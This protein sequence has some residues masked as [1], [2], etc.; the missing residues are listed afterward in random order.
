LET[1][2]RPTVEIRIRP[3]FGGDLANGFLEVLATLSP[4]E[5]SIA[6]AGEVLRERLR[7]GIQTFVALVG[8]QVVGTASLVLEKKFI[9]RGGHVGH[10]EDVAVRADY[11]GHGIGRSLVRRLLAAAHDAG[12][13]KVILNCKEHNI[14]FYE[15]LGFRRNET[16]MRYDLG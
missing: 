13:Y 11:Q 8:S 10:I 14:P 12:C 7:T 1:Q 5:L 16:E 15:R 6:E 2:V 3:L 4:V 9:H